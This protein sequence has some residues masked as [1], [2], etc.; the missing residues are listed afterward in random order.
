[1]KKRMTALLAGLMAAAMLCTSAFAIEASPRLIYSQFDSQKRNETQGGVT[2]T[3]YT[4]ANY[5]QSGPVGNST[6]WIEASATVPGGTMSAQGFMLRSDMTVLGASPLRTDPNSSSFMWAQSGDYSLSSNSATYFGSYVSLNIPGYETVITPKVNAVKYEN[7][8]CTAV[9]PVSP[10]NSSLPINRMG[11]TYG[12]IMDHG[13]NGAPDL[14]AA[15]GVDGTEGYVTS[16]DFHPAANASAESM[17]RYNQ[18][19]AENNNCIP[20]YDLEM[21]QIGWFA[22]TEPAEPDP[23]T[24]AK[25]DELS[26]QEVPMVENPEAYALE[27]DSLADFNPLNRYIGCVGDNG[28][29]G[30]MRYLDFRRPQSSTVNVYDENG[31]VVD[32]FTFTGTSSCG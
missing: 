23:D 5:S 20:L 1:M 10:S 12:S 22:F 24:Q 9:G 31:N 6:A 19:L 26:A 11:L 13:Q 16:W 2:Y 14:F 32:Q 25:I 17:A 28:T 3:I 4:R 27:R 15:V 30:Y 18:E 7:G 21:N 29:E 8:R